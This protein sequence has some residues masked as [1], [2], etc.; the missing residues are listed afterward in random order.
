ME[1]SI[2]KVSRRFNVLWK[3]LAIAF[4][5]VCAVAGLAYHPWRV[6]HGVMY[7]YAWCSV[8]NFSSCEI[9]EAW[10]DA[11][12]H[13]APREK[14]HQILG[15]PTTFDDGNKYF[16]EWQ[17]GAAKDWTLVIL[18]HEPLSGEAY[19]QSPGFVGYIVRHESGDY[20]LRFQMW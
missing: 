12:L 8:L 18:Y 6:R 20:A 5:L 1:Q 17:L 3:R 4:A 13:G 9:P 11:T 15:K 10:K 16:D 14:I 7:S 19:S 2:S